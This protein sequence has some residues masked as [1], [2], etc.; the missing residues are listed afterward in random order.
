MCHGK[1]TQHVQHQWVCNSSSL[2][3]DEDGDEG[4][5]GSRDRKKDMTIY[6]CEHTLNLLTVFIRGHI[7]G[8][9]PIIGL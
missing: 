5:D 3:W 9:M 6:S 2:S 1:L 7:V 4:W 8:R